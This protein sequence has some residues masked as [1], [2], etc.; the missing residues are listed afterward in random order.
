MQQLAL[1]AHF[2]RYGDMG[3]ETHP[4]GM[5]TVGT[6]DS[7]AILTVKRH[8]LGLAPQQ[9]GPATVRLFQIE[10]IIV[11]CRKSARFQREPAVAVRLCL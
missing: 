5:G 6:E 1:L 7:H 8:D 4:Q 3:I 2:L 9:L 10:M 11:L